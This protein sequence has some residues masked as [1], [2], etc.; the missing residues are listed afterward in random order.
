MSIQVYDVEFKDKDNELKSE[1][2]ILLAY[3]NHLVRECRK[4][5]K[6]KSYDELE[7]GERFDRFQN[8]LGYFEEKLNYQ[9][10]KM[11]SEITYKKHKELLSELY[12]ENCLYSWEY[13][14]DPMA[15]LNEYAKCLR[16]K[17]KAV[18]RIYDEHE[19]RRCELIR[20]Y[21]YH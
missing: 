20:G 19:F 5:T 10:S 12:D 13:T 15:D 4:T 11:K 2:A 18:I 8:R 3:F 16:K 7:N 17:V 6:G 9:I 1:G 14:D 21:G